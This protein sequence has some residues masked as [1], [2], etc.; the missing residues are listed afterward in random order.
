MTTPNQI[1]PPN[2]NYFDEAPYKEAAAYL[3]AN[4]PEALKQVE[5][6]VICGSGLGGLASTLD[7]PRVEFDYKNIPNF[8]VSTVPGHAGKLVFGFLSGKPTVCMVGRK[9][10]YEGHSLLRTVFPIRVMK[11]L[12]VKT[13]IVTNA[14]GGLNPSFNIADIMVIE[15]HLSLP[16]IGGM[17]ALIGPNVDFFGT[18]FPAVSDAYDF[19]LRVIAFKAAE[20]IGLPTSIMHEGVYSFVAGPSFESRAEARHL[21]NSGGDCVGMSTVPEVVVARHAGIRVLGLSLI[22]NNVNQSK[23]KSAKDVAL[24]LASR[25]DDTHAIKANH[26]EVLATSAARSADMQALVK[27]IVELL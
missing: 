5:V 14:A 15:D 8:A 18:R 21:R 4:L 25:D 2:I 24:G 23:G 13:L 10:A 17:N 6:M 3:I 22:T 16:G 1:P 9:H 27:K 7:E 26:E 12:Q 11:L 19:D 20:E